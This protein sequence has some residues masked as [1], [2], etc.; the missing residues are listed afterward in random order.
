MCTGVVLSLLRDAGAPTGALR[1]GSPLKLK[2]RV[3]ADKTLLFI[4]SRLGI[5]VALAA[6]TLFH[7]STSKGGGQLPLEVQL[8]GKACDSFASCWLTLFAS[9][10]YSAMQAGAE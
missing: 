3:G 4:D 5:I 7:T 10:Q 8:L 9:L 6:L 1:A 2:S